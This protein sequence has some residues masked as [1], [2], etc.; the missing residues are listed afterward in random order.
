MK[1]PPRIA[2][3]GKQWTIRWNGGS[4]AALATVVEVGGGLRECELGGLAVLDPFPLDAICDG[5]HNMPLI[6][7]PNRIRDG[8]YSYGGSYYQLALTDPALHNAIHG[9]LRWCNWTLREREENRIV[10][11]ALLHPQP[12]YPFTLD[13]AVAYTLDED[14]LTTRIT[15]TNL[16]DRTC[17]YGCGQHPYITCGTETISSLGLELDAATRLLTDTQQIP[18]K[19]EAVAGSPCDFRGGRNIGAQKLDCAFTDLARDA[20]GKAWARVTSP[21]GRRVSLWVDETF[22]Y[23]QI[24]TGD[25]LALARRRVGL[26][27]EPMTCAPNGFVSGDGLIR[28][29]PGESVPALWGLVVG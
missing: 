20:K 13:V 9:L 19:T 11:A 24:Y 3:S 8:C 16:G 6:P 23:L 10:V 28:L 29:A 14:G 22:R 21:E 26:A 15:A 27:V 4:G 7:W 1:S 5:A 17:P 25:T 18:T 12:G 2:P